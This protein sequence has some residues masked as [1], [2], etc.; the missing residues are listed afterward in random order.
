MLSSHSVPPYPCDDLRL[1]PGELPSRGNNKNKSKSEKSNSNKSKNRGSME[2]G[3]PE[4]SDEEEEKK[5]HFQYSDTGSD[6]GSDQ[7]R[8]NDS[9]DSDDSDG[10]SS[11]GGE[12]EESLHL[13][14][15][16]YRSLHAAHA[17]HTS[18]RQSH[19]VRHSIA[20][21]RERTSEFSQQMR[22]TQLVAE[23]EVDVAYSSPPSLK[24][25][26]ARSI[27][28]LAV[29]SR[30]AAQALCLANQTDSPDLASYCEEYVMRNLDSALCAGGRRVRQSAMLDLLAAYE[31]NPEDS[32]VVERPKCTL[33]ADRGQRRTSPICHSPAANEN[34]I[35]GYSRTQAQ[36]QNNPNDLNNSGSIGTTTTT[37]ASEYK[38]LSQMGVSA[39]PEVSRRLRAIKKTLS[40]LES[41]ETHPADPASKFTSAEETHETLTQEQREK[42]SRKPALLLEQERFSRLKS[43][44][45]EEEGTFLSRA[46]VA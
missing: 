43:R 4:G 42:L 40:R 26:C 37:S 28:R 12:E 19:S 30:T 25:L 8:S 11:S 17:R 9:D 24:A 27:A 18:K 41:L 35:E 45:E 23:T 32:C 22:Q 1:L 31:V 7:V 14:V 29:N 21:F 34:E 6:S 46:S 44:L 38:R 15:A 5:G 33:P 3:I 36:A 10:N 39:L 2:F 13:E 20:L 16:T